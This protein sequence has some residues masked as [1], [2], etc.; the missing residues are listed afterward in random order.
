MMRKQVLIILIAMVGATNGCGLTANAQ[1]SLAHP[2]E[3]FNGVSYDLQLIRD[4]AGI[5]EYYHAYIFTPVCD[6]DICKPVYINLYWDLLGNYVRYAIP[7]EEPLTKMDHAEFHPAEYEKLHQILADPKSLLND[8]KMEELVESTTRT[9]PGE[10]DAVTGATT[11][12][13]QA[14][15]IPGALYTCYT[16]WH[17]VHGSVVD[18]IANITDS[19]MDTQLLSHFLTSKNHHYQYYALDRVVDAEGKV[20]TA[21]EQ[22]VVDLIRSPNVFLATHVL[23]RLSSGYFSDAE[24]QYWL[25]ETFQTG[26]YRLKLGV[27][28][29]L[30]QLSLTEGLRDLLKTHRRSFNEDIAQR[31]EHLLNK[32]S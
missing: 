8:Y 7:P 6:D 29:K 1:D 10:V 12:S 14:V 16:L 11:K 26:S 13:L 18:T 24:G 20:E 2:V 21:Y 3:A 28:E 27:L 22:K 4:S 25:W 30:N 17:I 31:I 23:K 9:V 19:I 32:Q 5:P 15:V